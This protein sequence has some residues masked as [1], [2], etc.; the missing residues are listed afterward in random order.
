M[1]ELVP[2]NS[3]PRGEN[4][5]LDDLPYLLKLGLSMQ[6]VCEKNNGIGLSAV[7]VGIPLNFFIINIAKE[8]RFFVNCRY[9]PLSEEKIKSIEGCL[10]LKG[11]FFEVER[12]ADIVVKGKELNTNTLILEDIEEKPTGIMNAVFQHEIEHSL[13]ITVDLIGKEV[14]LW[15]DY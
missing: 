8:Y 3:I 10:S 6:E 15:R 9:K 5:K 14:F 4:C 11:R 1:N 12:F 2:L 13:L 7:Q